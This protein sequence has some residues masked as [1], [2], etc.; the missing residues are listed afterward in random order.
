MVFFLNKKF[1]EDH[2]FTRWLRPNMTENLVTG[3]LNKKT[4][5]QFHIMAHILAALE[6]N[7]SLGFQT[8]S[9]TNWVDTHRRWLEG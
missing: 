1:T 6:E 9:D 7:L 8:R 3:T 5:K 4:N 2:N